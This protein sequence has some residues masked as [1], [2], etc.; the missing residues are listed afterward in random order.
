M[1]ALDLDGTLLTTE[2]QL[3]ERTQKALDRTV[4]AGIEVV[5]VT[6][7][8]AAG[9][10][11]EVL[12]WKEIRYVISSNGAVVYDRHADRILKKTF[13]KRQDICRLTKQLQK[14]RIIYTVFSDGMGYTD[15]A[16]YADLMAHFQGTPILPYMKKSRRVAQDPGKL[17]DS[18][19]NL[20][21]RASSYEQREEMLALIK[22]EAPVTVIRTG[23]TD[24]EILS[25]EADKGKALAVVSEDCGILPSE[26]TA[27]GDNANDIEMLRYVGFPVIM[28]NSA[29]EVYQINGYLTS[30]N[31][32][33]GVANVLEYLTESG[34][35]CPGKS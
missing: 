29:P 28:G 22:Q 11:E 17:L 27:F 23:K 1:V 26:I 16:T 24:A 14:Q 8:S 19:E 33:D 31:D 34:G 21:F 2:K 3:T 6:G 20:W 25:D 5:V 13:L 32:E 12:A 35:L 9:I 4:Q 15:P 30:S 7:R 18:V 10:P